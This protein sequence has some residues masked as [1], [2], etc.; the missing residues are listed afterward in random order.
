VQIHPIEQ[1]SDGLKFRLIAEA[2]NTRDGASIARFPL[3][4]D[5]PLDKPHINDDTRFVA[6]KLMD[7][8]TQTWQNYQPQPTQPAVVPWTPLT[9]A[10]PTSNPSG[11]FVQPATPPTT[12][13]APAVNNDFF[14]TP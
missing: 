3:D 2:I 4:L 10:T 5:P 6:R 1:T 8:M 7:Q 13:P 12:K 9:P 11:A 14:G